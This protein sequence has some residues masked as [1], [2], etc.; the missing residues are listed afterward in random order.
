MGIVIDTDTE[1]TD[2]H[3]GCRSD[4]LWPARGGAI[5]RERERERTG[6]GWI[7]G[8]GP[9]WGDVFVRERRKSSLKAE[10]CQ[11]K[12]RVLLVFP[13]HFALPSRAERVCVRAWLGGDVR[14][15]VC[16]QSWDWARGM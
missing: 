3:P 6:S 15:G 9:A 13:L 7:D 4:I 5:E 10:R 11:K 2:T 8:W 12:R 1:C 16:A 14:Y